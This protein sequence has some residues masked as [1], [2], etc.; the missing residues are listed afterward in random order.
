[1]WC[2]VSGMLHDQW[3]HTSVVVGTLFSSLGERSVG[4]LHLP[5]I[6]LTVTPA[7]FFE[8]S[9][10]HRMILNLRQTLQLITS[11]EGPILEAHINDIWRKSDRDL[12]GSIDKAEVG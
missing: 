5:T 10:R 2:L 9:P 11:L 8:S 6:S 3:C 1:M 4:M 7:S 12:S